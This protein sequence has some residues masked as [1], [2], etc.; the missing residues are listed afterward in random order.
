MRRLLERMANL[1]ADRVADR[2]VKGLGD[3]RLFIN[4]IVIL[5][6]PKGKEKNL[7]TLRFRAG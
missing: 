5:I 6:L 2:V 4:V 7:E 1:L 3:A